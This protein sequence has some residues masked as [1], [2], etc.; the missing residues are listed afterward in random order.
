M[1]FFYVTY[2][3]NERFASK[4]VSPDFG[5]DKKIVRINFIITV[6]FE[7]QFE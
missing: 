6:D 5:T 4:I 7:F 3:R 2:E 1:E